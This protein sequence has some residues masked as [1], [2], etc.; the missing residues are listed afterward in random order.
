M[1]GAARRRR[2]PARPRD[3]LSPSSV[4]THGAASF[5]AGFF[6]TVG[7]NPV[8]VIKNRLMNQA[9]SGEGRM[10]SGMLDCATKTIRNEGVLALYKGF[11]PQWLRLG[12]WCMV[13]FISFEQYK[14]LVRGLVELSS[15]H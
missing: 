8:D 6:A 5:A 1:F 14:V 15:A 12:P 3:S 4:L 13:M 10:Y 7:C 9:A 2:P 11:V